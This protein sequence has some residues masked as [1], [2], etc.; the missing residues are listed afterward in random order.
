MS[1]VYTRRRIGDLML[2]SRSGDARIEHQGSPT[3]P[4]ARDADDTNGPWE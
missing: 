1:R 3:V 2:D 4:L